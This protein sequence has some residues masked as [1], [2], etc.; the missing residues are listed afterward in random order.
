MLE[1]VDG[2]KKSG[3]SFLMR[4]GAMGANEILS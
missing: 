4:K 3:L 1:G 2:R